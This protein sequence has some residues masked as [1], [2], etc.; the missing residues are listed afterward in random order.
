L[1]LTFSATLAKT[2]AV[3]PGE[4]GARETRQKS[5]YNLAQ[6]VSKT[7][8]GFHPYSRVES[9]ELPPPRAP[10]VS[11]PSTPQ[12]PP[13]P[14]LDEESRLY[15]GGSALFSDDIIELERPVLFSHTA[16][17][18][19]AEMIERFV[20]QWDQPMTICLESIY[21][22]Y[23][24][25]L[26]SIQANHFGE[27]SNELREHV[28]STIDNQ[29][30]RSFQSTLTKARGA[31]EM[32]KLGLTLHETDLTAQKKK[33][34]A[35][36]KKIFCPRGRQAAD[37]SVVDMISEVQAY[38]EVSHKRF[39]DS[40]CLLVEFDF[41]Q[42]LPSEMPGALIEMLDLSQADARDRCARWLQK[43]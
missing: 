17:A 39:V 9:L 28:S 3:R 29:I 40:I 5:Y 26:L 31:L 6:A 7:K 30:R 16:A 19:K 14:Y 42:K 37:D 35:D 12:T 38:F 24:E 23:R 36:Y 25:Y 22:K 15:S 10:K 2:N 21:E 33:Y 32:E 1:L 18:K 27:Y 8:P 34:I 13:G 11:R 20:E 43:A 4:M 41:I